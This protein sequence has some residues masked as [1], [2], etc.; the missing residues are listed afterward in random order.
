M[1]KKL[2]IPPIHLHW[3]GNWYENRRCCCYCRSVAVETNPYIWAWLD[4]NCCFGNIWL[5]FPLPFAFYTRFFH[6][7]EVSAQCMRVE[8]T[9]KCASE[10]TTHT[11]AYWAALTHTYRHE[12]IGM[13]FPMCKHYRSVYL[14]SRSICVVLPLSRLCFRSFSIVFYSPSIEIPA[15]LTTTA[16]SHTL[17]THT[18]TQTLARTFVFSFVCLHGNA[19]AARKQRWWLSHRLNQ[20]LAVSFKLIVS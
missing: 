15:L 18:I 16:H 1:R 12:S 8:S 5:F 11:C 19:T 7:L 17:A 2:E 10:Q 14:Q 4:R 6:M 3:P 20:H 9:S 13:L